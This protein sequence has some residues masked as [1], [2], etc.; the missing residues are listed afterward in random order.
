MAGWRRSGTLT[1]S[2]LRGQV[3]HCADACR[4]AQI[5]RLAGAP[6]Y[7][8]R[9]LASL[10]H[11]PSGAGQLAKLGFNHLKSLWNLSLRIVTIPLSFILEMQHVTAIVNKATATM[12]DWRR[13]G[14]HKLRRRL[15]MV[16][17]KHKN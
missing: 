8:G 17:S 14:A 6:H 10:Y 1:R 15:R 11:R 3:S 13:S 9:P 16:N 4:R 12:A 5:G 2:G 7:P